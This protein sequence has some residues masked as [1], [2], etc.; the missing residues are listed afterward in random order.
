MRANQLIVK[1]SST[2][3][4]FM[5]FQLVSCSY[6]P[7]IK[8]HYPLRKLRRELPYEGKKYKPVFS[9]LKKVWF[10]PFY[11]QKEYYQLI[12]DSNK[13]LIGFKVEK[14]FE[15]KI[16]KKFE[17]KKK[18]KYY[19]TQI[20]KREYKAMFAERARQDIHLEIVDNTN[21]GVSKRYSSLMYF[22]PRTY[23]PSILV[24]QDETLIMLPT[25][26]SVYFNTEDMTILRGPLKMMERPLIDDLPSVEYTGQGIVVRV[27]IEKD[28]IN[29]NSDVTIIHPGGE[30][31]F[32][33]LA[34]LFLFKV[35]PVFKYATDEQFYEYLEDECDFPAPPSLNN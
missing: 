16:E 8:K 30:V 23:L 9:N 19:R 27:D 26:E 32:V 35:R 29:G 34:D 18:Y 1:F 17:I 20:I 12:H 22:F 21:A 4:V 25:G 7:K 11:E 5:L 13:D 6:R 33:A 24:D 3:V 31:C 15:Y 10:Y 28:K 14:D 2:C